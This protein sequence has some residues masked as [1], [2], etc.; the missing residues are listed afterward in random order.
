MKDH[1]TIQ[2]QKTEAELEALIEALCTIPAL[3]GQ[4]W[5]RA[6]FVQDWLNGNG[7]TGS[8]I[9]RSGNVIFPTPAILKSI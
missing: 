7:L 1:I 8:W 9:D 2:A 4:E 6:E 5:A 3:L